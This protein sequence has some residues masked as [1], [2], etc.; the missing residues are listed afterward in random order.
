[1]KSLG[2]LILNC[3]K[4]NTYKERDN[5]TVF[6]DCFRRGDTVEGIAKDSQNGTV[7]LAYLCNICMSNFSHLTFANKNL[8]RSNFLNKT[9]KIRLF[10]QE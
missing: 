5:A 1:M 8:I 3:S 2:H 4:I 7:A 6:G 9:A 10:M